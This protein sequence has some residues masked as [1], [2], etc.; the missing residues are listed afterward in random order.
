MDY[1]S[2][3]AIKERMKIALCAQIALVGGPAIPSRGLRQV[4][5]HA[6][7]MGECKSKAKLR[8]RKSLLCRPAEP[9]NGLTRI[10]WG[11][12]SAHVHFP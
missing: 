5:L 10:T 9:Q 7:A 1:L 2:R 12:R 6:I 11:T 3:A 4:L 8:M